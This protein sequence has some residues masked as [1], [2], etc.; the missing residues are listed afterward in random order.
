MYR[1]SDLMHSFV[2]LKHLSVSEAI[3]KIRTYC[4]YRDR[5]HKE[6][7][8]KLYAWGLY[9]REV[10]QVM[11][12]MMEEDLLNE[13]RF[14]RSYARGYFR[15]KQWGRYKIRRELQLRQI[16]ARLIDTAMTEIDEDEYQDT[17]RK[18]IDKKLKTTQGKPMERRQ[19]VSEY[20]MRKGYTYAEFKHA[21]EEKGVR[22]SS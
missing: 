12:Q 4:N 7:R 1:G 18:L 13:E 19:K 10:D 20:L 8:D 16:H 21:L 11:L 6:V 5:C 22:K 14:A 15:T 17:V 9:K 2:S 3:I